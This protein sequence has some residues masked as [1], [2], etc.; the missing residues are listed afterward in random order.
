MSDWV[1]QACG[2]VKSFK[3]GQ[4]KIDVL[5]ALDLNLATGQSMAIIGSSGSGKSTLLQLSLIHI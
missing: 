1:L 2:L 5:K 3:D 4:R